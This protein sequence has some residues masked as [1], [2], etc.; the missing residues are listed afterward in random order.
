MTIV[1]ARIITIALQL[2]HATKPCCMS[3]KVVQVIVDYVEM[4]GN[5]QSWDSLTS[6][7]DNVVLVHLL[8]KFGSFRVD[9]NNRHCFTDNNNRWILFHDFRIIAVERSSNLRI[10]TSSD[11]LAC[12]TQKP[13]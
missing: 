1:E 4:V 3:S 10:V 9:K 6:L 8:R 7:N 2:H 12:D 5:C 11:S 13:L